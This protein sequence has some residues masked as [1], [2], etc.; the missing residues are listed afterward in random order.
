MITDLNTAF[1]HRPFL[2]AAA[3]PPAYLLPGQE[4]PVNKFRTA[5][6]IR[7]MLSAFTQMQAG[8]GIGAG[9]VKCTKY[10]RPGCRR[11][12]ASQGAEKRGKHGFPGYFF[13]CLTCSALDR[14]G[15]KT[16]ISV[17]CPMSRSAKQDLPFVRLLSVVFLS[18]NEFWKSENS[19]EKVH[20]RCPW[21]HVC[22]VYLI[23]ENCKSA[24][25][26]PLTRNGG[27]LKSIKQ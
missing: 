10:G 25:Y 22:I 26:E 21:L 6:N 19:R 2:F 9:V 27:S 4:S 24:S 20:T 15:K 1:R 12:S 11:C 13:V 16:D 14:W 3:P 18:A 8:H 17:P 23:Y 7:G 5:K